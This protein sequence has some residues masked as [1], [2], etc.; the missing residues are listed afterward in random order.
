M[1]QVRIEEF[2]RDKKKFVYID[3]SNINTSEDF[4][5]L[6]TQAELVIAKY[7]MRSLY[8]I[9]NVENIRFDTGMKKL[10]IKYLEHNKPYVKCGAIIGLDGVKKIMISAV[11]R[12]SG[13]DNITFAFSKEQAV[14]LLLKKEY[15]ELAQ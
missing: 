14:E 11:F 3:F 13:R 4:I 2:T 9:T 1:A 7:P 5:E 8:T 12:L 10:A 15:E 6:M